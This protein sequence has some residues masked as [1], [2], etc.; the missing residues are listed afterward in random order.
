MARDQDWLCTQPQAALVTPAAGLA[1]F[2]HL[3]WKFQD[4]TDFHARA[5]QYIAE[6]LAHDY[7][8]EFVGHGS[9]EQLWA[10]LTELT[11]IADRLKA[12]G[13]GVTPASKFYA[14]LDGTDIVDPHT[15]V[16]ISVAALDRA[17]QNGYNG[18]R[19]VV[20][21]TTLA[22]RPDQRAALSHFEFL[23]SRTMA[24]LPFSALCAYDTH[25]L[26]A[27]DEL[28][29]LHPDVG[30]RAPR[31][32]LHPAPQATFALTGN[33]D[34]HSDGLYTTALQ[35]IWSLLV[36]DPLI[37][38]AQDLEFISHQQ[39]YTLDHYAR[40]DGRT[41]ILRTGQRIP[42]RLLDV[43]HLTNVEL[44]PAPPHSATQATTPS[45]DQI[46]YA[47]SAG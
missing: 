16:A 5:A 17:I 1:S 9:R 28:I 34:L 30:E 25:Q 46:T 35:R 14:V 6:G 21:A 4:R 24:G 32:R 33:I 13:V 2:E 37:I 11:G 20:D 39:L 31:F 27:A 38:D 36:D 26:P 40:T 47:G 8:T 18:F 22:H 41:V 10:E 12:G 3:G 44:Q 15:A 42:T 23:L 7:W 43:L 29:C 45:G 19:V